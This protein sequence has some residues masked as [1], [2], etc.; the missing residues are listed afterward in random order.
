MSKPSSWKIVLSIVTFLVCSRAAIGASQHPKIE[1]GYAPGADG[2]RLFYRMIGHGRDFVVFLHGGPG[3]NLQAGGKGLEPLAEGRTLLLYDQ[4]GGGRSDIITDPSRLTAGDHVRD[5]EA[6]REH[7]GIS[8]F[9]IIGLSWGS[10]LAA[11]YAAEHP[12]RVAR[13]VFL[14]P[15]P[16]AR[17][18]YLQQRVEKTNSALSP[19]EVARMR[20]ITKLY[21]TATDGQAISLCHEQFQIV[22]KTYRRRSEGDGALADEIC[23]VPP[24]GIRNFWIVNDAVF[25]SLGNYDFRPKLATVRVPA[26]VIEGMESRVPLDA[27][28]EW[29][30]A[31]PNA[32]L[33]LVSGAGHNIVHDRRDAVIAAIRQFLAGKWPVDARRPS[34]QTNTDFRESKSTNSQ[35]GGVL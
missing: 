14:S 33:L 5:L 4:R 1:E 26:L 13:V 32:R 20:E 29:A 34:Q 31:A 2:V 7:F 3:A 10:G 35:T 24:A 23:S 16:P 11:L 6:L 9:S 18:P 8:R 25:K 15:M 12:D 27:T 21:P 19:E 22:D 17:V 28:E 30:R